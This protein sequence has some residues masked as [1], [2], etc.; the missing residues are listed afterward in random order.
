MKVF[1]ILT[2][3]LLLS[4]LTTQAQ[5]PTIEWQKS[6]GGSGDDRAYSIKQTSDGGYIVAGY[7]Y[8][9]DGDVNGNYGY[10]DYWIVKLNA[11][12]D[13]TWTKSYGGLY[14]DYAYSISQ[15]NDGGYIVAGTTS[16]T[17][18]DISGNNGQ[19]DYWILKL[20]AIGDTLWTKC[21]GGSRNESAYSISQISDGGYIIAGF[22]SSND[23]DVSGNNGNV[24][25]ADY[26]IVKLNEIGDTLWT[27][28]LGG[29]NGD[30]ANYISQTSDGGYIVAGYSYS[31][32]GYVSGNHGQY[33]YWIVKIDAIGDTLWTKCLGG[34]RNETTKSISQTS[35][36]GYI[37]AGFSNSSDGDVSVNKDSSDAWIVKLN[38]TGDTL[39][40]KCLGGSD[41]DYAWSIKQ[42]TD[43]GYIIAGFSSSNDGDVSGN[44][45]NSDYWIV[46]LN[47]I[48]D[49]LWTK[50][51]GGSN[52]DDARSINQT[53]D[54]GYIVAGISRS[55]DGDVSGNHGGSDYW[56]VKLSP[57]TLTSVPEI[58]QKDLFSLYP[59]PAKNNVQLIMSNEQLKNVRIEIV[60]IT[61]KT[62]YTSSLRG[63]KQA[64]D[65]SNQAK[66]IY[67]VK[68]I[69]EGFVSV[70]KLVLE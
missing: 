57:D 49:T 60:S 10:A 7:S 59:N 24:G 69:G 18:G 55:N 9:N 35:D 26:W 48:G 51:L 68:L 17:D 25:N 4:I 37:V 42:T 54:G 32:D 20:N 45:G 46:K 61:G 66:G 63:T 23:G 11:N 38:A 22:S 5:A 33:D 50:C 53:S 70:E 19:N 30:Y 29:S 62:V 28:C 52:S 13:T 1:T 15:T 44:H 41:H 43:G 21:L 3:I 67:F 14:V 8:S 6:F 64:I 40:T 58:N 27:K 12:G 56:I 16:S 31:N 2:A 47:A 36:G 65:L 39:W 34:S